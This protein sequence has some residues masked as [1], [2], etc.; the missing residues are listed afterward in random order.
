VDLQLPED[1]EEPAWI[2]PSAIGMS[3]FSCTA[4]RILFYVCYTYWVDSNQSC[5]GRCYGVFAAP[6]PS[7]SMH[8]GKRSE[9]LRSLE[10]EQ[11]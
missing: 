5:R 7:G 3:F 2:E 4:L 9:G 8:Q 6:V 11:E 10:V 1:E